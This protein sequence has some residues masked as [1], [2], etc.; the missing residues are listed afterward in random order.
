MS[1]GL[2]TGF[3]GF[4]SGCL[5]AETCVALK[6]N[7]R[8][9]CAPSPSCLAEDSSRFPVLSELLER[10]TQSP[11]YQEGVSYSLLKVAEL[12]LVRVAEILLQYGADLIFEGKSMGGIAG[13]G[14]RRGGLVLVGGS[15]T[16]WPTRPLSMLNSQAATQLSGPA[17]VGPSSCPSS[18]CRELPC[19]AL[20]GG[21]QWS[22]GRYCFLW[23]SA[24]LQVPRNLPS[25]GWC[26]ATPCPHEMAK[27]CY[28]S[29]T[30]P[31]GAWVRAPQ[32]PKPLC[33][34]GAGF[35]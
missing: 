15:W 28:I 5:G 21:R 34:V 14:W 23:G 7:Q 4:D 19:R 9:P 17:F 30:L 25:P 20:G 24:I 10:E 11:F 27:V 35:L 12:G 8:L 16:R 3:T 29:L 31:G 18:W 22:C 6:P 33:S 13:D 26:R 2:P 1:Q 32:E